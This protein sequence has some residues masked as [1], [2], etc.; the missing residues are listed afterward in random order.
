[1]LKNLLAEYHV[2]RKKQL[3]TRGSLQKLNH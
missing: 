3:S 1:M 2:D